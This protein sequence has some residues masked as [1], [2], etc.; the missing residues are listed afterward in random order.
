MPALTYPTQAVIDTWDVRERGVRSGADTS[1]SEVLDINGSTAERTFLV[2]W[3]FR[4]DFIKYMIG[5]GALWDDSGTTRLS[6]LLPRTYPN[7]PDWV[8]RRVT[9]VMGHKWTNRAEAPGGGF[10][11]DATRHHGHPRYQWTDTQENVF[12]DAAV[13]IQYEH[14]TYERIEDD[15]AYIQATPE[16]SRYVITGETTPKAEALQ[17]PG[18]VM[19]FIRSSGTD[20]PQGV[21]IPFNAARILPQETF[22]LTWHRVPYDV[23]TPESA[24]YELI[25]TGDVGTISGG[26]T[27]PYYGAVNQFSF[28]GRPPGTVVLSGVRPILLRSPLGDALEWDIEY[29]FSYDPNGWCYKYYYG[30]GSN[31]AFNGFYL[32]GRST[33]HYAIT[34]LPDNYSIYNARDINKLFSVDN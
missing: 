31:A 22:V 12:Q 27:T 25:Y 11:G 13:T 10:A 28:Y 6:R 15:D 17:L 19:K 8:A 5:Y 32:I 33:T 14:V 1:P 7:Y 3:A 21:S 23:W 34:A 16:L 18:A 20:A 26:V 4:R 9:R 24:L 30:T 2:K 29:T